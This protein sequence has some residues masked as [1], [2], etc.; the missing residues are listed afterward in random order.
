MI[1]GYGTFG[2]HADFEASLEAAVST[3]VSLVLVDDA[4]VIEST[5]ISVLTRERPPEEALA[6]VAREHLQLFHNDE[7]SKAETPYTVMTT[8]ICPHEVFI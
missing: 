4:G 7:I 5:R 2:V 3:R 1:F 8:C 6:A